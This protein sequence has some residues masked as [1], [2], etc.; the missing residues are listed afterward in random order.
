MADHSSD[1]SGTIKSN[2]SKFGFILLDDGET[3]LFV[4]P[5]QCT[6]FGGQIP[7]AG[8]RVLFTIGSDP[9]KG[10]P[11]ANDVR[12]ENGDSHSSLVG[13]APSYSNLPDGVDELQQELDRVE[14]MLS[15]V[16][17]ENRG[18]LG[19]I[20][21]DSGEKDMFVLPAQC[22]AFGGV[23]PPVGTALIY[24]VVSDPKTGRPRA[25]DVQPVDGDT[26]APNVMLGSNT[27]VTRSFEAM[28]DGNKGAPL[29]RSFDLMSA[30][31]MSFDTSEHIGSIKSSTGK[32]GFI[33]QDSGEDD[34]FVM[35]LQCTGFGSVLPQIGTKVVYS[36]GA[37]KKKG[38]PCAE[39]VRPL[40]QSQI[41]SFTTPAK[42]NM[43]SVTPASSSTC[44][45][46]M[47][48]NRGNLG[49][50]TQ[51]S[52]GPDMFVLPQQCQSFN[53]MIPP[54]GAR[55]S[56][57]VSPDPK[58]GRPR[59]E[60]VQLLSF[61]LEK[62]T[63]HQPVLVPR[64]KAP[65]QQPRVVPRLG[66]MTGYVKHSYPTYGFI[67]QDN[68]ES[69]M[70]F[71]PMQCQAFG[72][73]CPPAGTRVS[74]GVETDAKSGK[75]RAA[76]VQVVAETFA[77]PAKKARVSDAA[78]QWQ[79]GASSPAASWH[80]GANLPTNATGTMKKNNGKFGFIQQDTGAADMFVMPAQCI[81]FGGRLPEMGT[82]VMYAIGH[83]P[84]KQSPMA[85]EVQPEQ[86]EEVG[87]TGGAQPQ[88][89]QPIHSGMDLADT[90]YKSGMIKQCSD[91][92]GFILQDD[93]E[94]DMFV[95]PLQCKDF[96]N[97]TV[98]P[99]GTRVAFTVEMDSKTGR[100]RAGLIVPEEVYYE[101]AAMGS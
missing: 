57:G 25:D 63:S 77:P 9:K 45:G 19:F 65:P 58:T 4:M 15:G 37:D 98:P 8:T 68:G 31:T 6:G 1:V 87:V 61:H 90:Q 95:L 70:F 30:G 5:A 35:P 92:F 73:V 28:P 34:L 52:G 71:M 10:N 89:V 46:V 36:I 11:C 29:K 88:H 83:D 27:P 43:A 48:E 101:Y 53:G 40:G 56:Y 38:W 13:V 18:N 51:D 55:V 20:A 99:I 91:K 23:L 79:D 72:G 93:G 32:S 49:F 26:W 86:F 14:G 12:P 60:N 94:P 64:S 33:K 100:P 2:G 7:P 85:I 17:K 75:P 54:V 41:A 69:D 16:M 24:S 81:G 66:R 59:A 62:D 22:Q 50:I 42:A 80:D 44:T 97:G 82:R 47:K 76:D 21:Q 96:F 84:Q 39:N 3:D 74:Y 67:T 78:A